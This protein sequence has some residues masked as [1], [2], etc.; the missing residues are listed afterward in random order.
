MFYIGIDKERHVVKIRLETANGM[1]TH[2]ELTPDAAK[3]F[4]KMINAGISSIEP[5]PKKD[6]R[7]S[8][9]D[10]LKI[11]SEP[12]TGVWPNPTT[13]PPTTLYGDY[14]VPVV[15]YVKIPSVKFGTS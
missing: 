4:V 6:E 15:D 2:F 12:K 14:N 5:E 1:I 9:L 7:K 11:P 8:I 3:S 13:L 10:G